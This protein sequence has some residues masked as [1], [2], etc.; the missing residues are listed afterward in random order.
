VIHR[1]CF[2]LSFLDDLASNLESHLSLFTTFKIDILSDDDNALTIR[3]YQSGPSQR[4]INKSRDDLIGLQVLVR[5]A[6]QKVAVDTTESITEYL[7]KLQVLTSSDGS[8]QF[9]SCD[10]YVNPLLVEKTDR[11]TYLY[12]VLFQ[13]KINKP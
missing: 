1:R 7:E 11:N 10:V 3:R 9:I 8:Y 4:F 2:D 13:A 6:D 5:N 12:S